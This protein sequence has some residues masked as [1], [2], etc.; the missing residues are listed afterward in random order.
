MKIIIDG[1]EL[2]EWQENIW[3]VYRCLHN[4]PDTEIYDNQFVA[5]LKLPPTIKDVPTY[6]I[7]YR[8]NY[9]KPFSENKLYDCLDKAKE[10]AD[11]QIQQYLKLKAFL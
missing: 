3:T 2:M 6:W 7:T 11:L 4:Y 10:Q 1:Y 8:D 9:M 5:I